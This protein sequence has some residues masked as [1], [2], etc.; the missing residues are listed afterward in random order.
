MN[1]CENCIFAVSW[2]FRGEGQCRRFPKVEQICKSYWCGEHRQFP[3]KKCGGSGRLGFQIC[4]A[5]HPGLYEPKVEFGPEDYM[6]KV[7]GK[8]FRCDCGCN[9]FKK[10]V[11]G[12][13]Y[14]CNA[15]E[16]IYQGEI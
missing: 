11:E 4:P 6:P 14:K 10:S 16:A 13:A 12:Q 9:V 3:C 8:S 1:T 5:C 2:T 15:C 7:K